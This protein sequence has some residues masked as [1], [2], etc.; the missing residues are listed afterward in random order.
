MYLEGEQE[1]CKRA[2]EK[3]VEELLF[4]WFDKQI[5]GTWDDRGCCASQANFC[6]L[7]VC[8]VFP[9]NEFDLTFKPKS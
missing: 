9:E 3:R 2:V 8:E 1:K 5:E 7:F 4:L 6:H